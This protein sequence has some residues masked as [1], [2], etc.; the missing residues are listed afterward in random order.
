MDSSNLVLERTARPCTVVLNGI[1]HKKANI[2]IYTDVSVNV[3][4]TVFVHIAI[5]S[6]F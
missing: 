1:V 6:A 5:S 2:F 3:P 4:V